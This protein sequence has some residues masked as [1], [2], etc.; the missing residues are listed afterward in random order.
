[1]RS[2]RECAKR[3][4]RALQSPAA[5]LRGG[6]AGVVAQSESERVHARARRALDHARWAVR[7][8]RRRRN[9]VEVVVTCSRRV[10]LRL[11]PKHAF[12]PVHPGVTS[13]AKHVARRV[14]FVPIR[15]INLRHRRERDVR[16]LPVQRGRARFDASGVVHR[17]RYVPDDCVRRTRH[18]VVEEYRVRGV[19]CFRVRE[20]AVA[21]EAP[22]LVVAPVVDVPVRRRRGI[23]LVPNSLRFELPKL[24]RW[25]PIHRE[26]LI[27]H[28]A[29]AVASCRV[30]TRRL[31]PPQR[32]G[33][34][35]R[36][37][38][39]IAHRIDWYVVPL[40]SSKAVLPPAAHAHRARGQLRLIAPV[41]RVRAAVV[42]DLAV[43]NRDVVIRRTA[44]VRNEDE[45]QSR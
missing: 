45:L 10:V 41:V 36:A 30:H 12:V 2:G 38:R 7:I 21:R 39:E 5:A 9:R 43:D 31:R 18:S 8:R 6:A 13:E 28:A 3:W 4:A 14:G 1:M 17:R 16:L 29:V 35:I 27:V 37:E 15:F 19:L 23:G 42:R 40:V 25:A 11:C 44:V 20:P 22:R 26:L 24:R 34:L 33:R 32:E